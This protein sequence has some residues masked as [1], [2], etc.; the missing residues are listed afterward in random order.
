MVNDPAAHNKALPQDGL[1]DTHPIGQRPQIAA[2]VHALA[3]RDDPELL[4]DLET[5]LDDNKPAV[6]LRVAAGIL[7]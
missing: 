1:Q 4:K 7:R 5:L 3:L 6:R 2:A